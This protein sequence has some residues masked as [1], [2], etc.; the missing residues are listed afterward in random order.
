[1]PAALQQERLLQIG[2]DKMAPANNSDPVTAPMFD[3]GRVVEGNSDR[4]VPTD[5]VFGPTN[6]TCGLIARDRVAAEKSGQSDRTGRLDRAK[7]VADKS[8]PVY[9]QIVRIFDLTDPTTDL[10]GRVKVVVVN[11]GGRV[12][13][14]AFVRIVHSIT[15]T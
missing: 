15:T 10:I 7:T 13:V 8:A 2:S 14:R 11:S 12:I 9:G 3:R 5:L 6:P 1:L 4:L